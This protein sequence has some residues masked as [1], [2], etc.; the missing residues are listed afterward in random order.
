MI[1]RILGEGQYDVPESELDRL[2]ALDAA[3]EAAVGNG[4][5]T[6]FASA[7]TELLAGVRA[8]GT[9]HAADALDVSDAVLPHEGA[10]LAEVRDLLEDDGL[11]PG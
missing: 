11:I 9:P 8:M 3:L 4:D 6:A 5:E 7:L 1:V 2:N 10:S